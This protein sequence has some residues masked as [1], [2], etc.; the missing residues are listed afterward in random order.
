M[1]VLL[2]AVH[3][4]ISNRVFESERAAEPR[5]TQHER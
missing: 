4:L 5:V 2:H 1:V 3:K